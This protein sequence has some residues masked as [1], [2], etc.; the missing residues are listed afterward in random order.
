M[1]GGDICVPRHEQHPTTVERLGTGLVHDVDPAGR[2]EHEFDAIQGRPLGTNEPKA[3]GAAV[4]ASH[5]RHPGPRR[6]GREFEPPVFPDLDL[7]RLA[8]GIEEA[9]PDARTC[10]R[11]LV[12]VH[13]PPAD[14]SCTRHDDVDDCITG[15]ERH[16]ATEAPEFRVEA[17]EVRPVDR[18]GETRTGEH[19]RHGRDLILFVN[20]T[21]RGQRTLARDETRTGDNLDEEGDHL[22]R[23]GRRVGFA[24]P[25]ANANVSDPL[26]RSERRFV[27][28][29]SAL[30]EQH[31]P[32]DGHREEEAGHH[33]VPRHRQRV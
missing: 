29:P 9:S 15:I 28:S 31:E 18:R 8:P 6:H 3:R 17:D 2:V 5:E 27:A 4:G 23:C 12:L 24:A 20:Q 30:R 14:R 11:Q 21:A 7:D 26:G 1:T 19:L 13:D 33:E 25:S 22:G 16:E 32:D 10:D